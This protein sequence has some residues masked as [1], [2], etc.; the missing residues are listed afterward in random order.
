MYHDF[1]NFKFE[2]KSDRTVQK[3]IMTHMGSYYEGAVLGA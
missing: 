2:Y 3:P 1:Y